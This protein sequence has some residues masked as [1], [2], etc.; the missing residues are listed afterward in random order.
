MLAAIS[1]SRSRPAALSATTLLMPIILN[2]AIQRRSDVSIA[3]MRTTPDGRARS[4]SCS[5]E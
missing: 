3:S 1:R 2:W 5:V 4:I